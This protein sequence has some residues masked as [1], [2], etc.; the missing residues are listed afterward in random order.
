MNT[1]KNITEDKLRE[2][3]G[4]ISFEEPSP[5]FMGNLLSRIEKEAV[6]LE[7]RKRLWTVVG[8]VA[9][10]IFGIFILPALVIY[11]CTIFIPGF[12]FTF[13]KINLH[14]DPT[15]LAVGFSVLML[16]ILDTLLRTYA[17]NRR[18]NE[19]SAKPCV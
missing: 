16:L 7:K 11:L 12:T 19:S 1:D 3:F 14:F 15:L 9:A 13:P 18:K 2:L 5:D 6:A 10:G 17:A 8:Q 4:E